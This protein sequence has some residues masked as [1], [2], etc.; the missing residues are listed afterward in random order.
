MRK[1]IRDGK[2]LKGDVVKWNDNLLECATMLMKYKVISGF[3]DTSIR[4]E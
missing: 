1:K 2:P 4:E 3:Y